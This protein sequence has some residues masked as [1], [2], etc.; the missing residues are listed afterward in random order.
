MG[1]TSS[2]LGVL[3]NRISLT[4]E[5]RFVSHAPRV[6]RAAVRWYL[7]LK[8]PPAEAVEDEPEPEVDLQLRYKVPRNKLDTL[9][10]RPD[11]SL[12]REQVVDGLFIVSFNV[13][14]NKFVESPREKGLYKHCNAK[15]LNWSYRAERIL[16]HLGQLDA[17]VICLQEVE[18]IAFETEFDPVFSAR[19]YTSTFHSD[20]VRKGKPDE[21][22]I[23]GLAIFVKRRLLEF[24]WE[25]QGYR[26]LTCGFKIRDKSHPCQGRD[27][28]VTT[29]HLAGHPDRHQER[30][31]QLAS[32]LKKLRKKRTGNEYSVV[33]GDFNTSLRKDQCADIIEKYGLESVYSELCKNEPTCVLTPWQTLNRKAVHVDHILYHREEAEQVSTMRIF[34]S[35]WEREKVLFKGLP[36]KEWPSDHLSIGVILRLRPELHREKKKKKKAVSVKEK[37]K[38]LGVGEVHEKIE[39]KREILKSL[40]TEDEWEQWIELEEPKDDK[41]L[42]KEE[43]ERRRERSKGRQAF[44][45]GLSSEKQLAIKELNK[46]K[47]LLKKTKRK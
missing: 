11:A 38:K 47:K 41:P 36:S 5:F 9:F 2:E 39:E 4:R 24:Q 16:Q 34:D 18:A 10:D 17:D 27:L 25:L 14:A 20:V 43:I 46:A 12:T 29:V 21:V 6:E 3:D 26:A 28:I 33:C 31:S 35:T 40:L 30:A 42:N 19:G 37:K 15:H 8:H 44:V 1:N 23:P 22:M 7:Q 45:S 32:T 13:L